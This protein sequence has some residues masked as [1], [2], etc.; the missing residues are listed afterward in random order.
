VVPELVPGAG[1]GAAIEDGLRAAAAGR[2]G[3]VAILLG[4]V[5]AVRPDD[6]CVA[7][8]TAAVVLGER[9]VEVHRGAMAVVP[10][11]EGTGTV[12]LA[13]LSA[14]DLAP[15]FG[16]ASFAEHER[17]GAVAIGWELHR[18]RRDVDTPDDLWDAAALGAGAR[19]AAVLA[20]HQELI[21][22]RSSADR[23]AQ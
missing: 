15:A 2:Q 14:A 20:S 9:Q 10:D 11:A 3:P 5:P 16:P 21:A 22:A 17:R 23:A 12:L 18:L 7:L 8:W 6:L 1:L 4:D 19:T 13:A